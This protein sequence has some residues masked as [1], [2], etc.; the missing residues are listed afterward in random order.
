MSSGIRGFAGDRFSFRSRQQRPDVTEERGCGIP[1]GNL[2]TAA[3]FQRSSVELRRTKQ[4]V[5]VGLKLA[6][7]IAHRPKLG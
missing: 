5:Y 3:E 6:E 1:I 7:A 4:T 2:A